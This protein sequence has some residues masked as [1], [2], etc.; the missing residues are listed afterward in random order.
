MKRSKIPLFL[1]AIS[2]FQY[3]ITFAQNTNVA[4]EEN[5]YETSELLLKLIKIKEQQGVKK[6]KTTNLVVLTDISQ[7]DSIPDIE[8]LETETKV[9]TKLRLSANVLAQLFPESTTT[10]NHGKNYIDYTS[11]TCIL[12]E[13]LLEQHETIKEELIVADSVKQNIITLQQKQE[14]IISTIAEMQEQLLPEKMKRAK[15]K[16]IIKR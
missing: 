5:N 4:L 15:I 16:N 2:V 11:I 3:S 9:D 10:D 7:M 8:E 13:A 1:I 12:M 14:E 6:I